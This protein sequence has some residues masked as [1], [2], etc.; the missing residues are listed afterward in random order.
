MCA[1][2]VYGF[3]KKRRT[4]SCVIVR[5]PVKKVKETGIVIDKPKRGK[6]KTVHTPENIAAVAETLCKV[7]S[8]SIHHRSQQFYISETSLR[9]ILDKDLGMMPYKVQLVQESK[10][11]EQPMRFRFTKWDCDRLTEDDDFGKKKIIFSNEAHF[12]LGGWVGKQA[13]LLHLGHRKLARI[14]WNANASKTSHCLVRILV[15]RHNFSSKMSKERLLQSV[16]IVIGPCWTN[17]CL[18]KLKRRILATFG[19]NNTALHATQPKQ[20]SMF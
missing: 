20:H 2:N 17:F 12:D 18:Q 3:F 10:T 7:P 6:P 8:T 19:F 5:Y 13:K 14:Y 9:W 1:K 16:A 4:V 11:I 15:Q